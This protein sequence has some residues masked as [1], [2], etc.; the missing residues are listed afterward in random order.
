MKNYIER[1]FFRCFVYPFLLLFT[2]FLSTACQ[3]DNDD[4]DVIK[5][6]IGSWHQTSKMINGTETVKDSTRMLIQINENH[7]CVLSDSSYAAVKASSVISRSGWSYTG[8]LFNLAIDLPASWIIHTDA[9]SLTLE[10][11]EFNNDGTI[12]KT[13]LKYYRVPNSKSN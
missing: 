11:A 7:I 3:K 5:S 10:R 2:L 9:N 6:I 8:G 1:N 13:V 4:E 12:G